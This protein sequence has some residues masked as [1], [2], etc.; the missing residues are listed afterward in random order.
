[1]LRRRKQP[2]PSLVAMGEAGGAE[3][4][5]R[6]SEQAGVSALPPFA[7]PR[8]PEARVGLA[9]CAQDQPWA[10]QQTAWPGPG[11]G[12]GDLPVNRVRVPEA[13]AGGGGRSWEGTAVPLCLLRLASPSPRR[14]DARVRLPV[15]RTVRAAPS[16]LPR[17]VVWEEEP[18]PRSEPVG[19]RS[20]RRLE[21]APRLP[22]PAVP[23]G[24]PRRR[25]AGTAPRREAGRVRGAR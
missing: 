13:A 8:R 15:R 14:C 12:R 7:F 5:R 20:G 9:Q 25:V 17:H 21:E 18:D 19:S 16:S 4:A 11:W 6:V 23:A 2:E 3:E 10:R 1:M 22:L 24:Q